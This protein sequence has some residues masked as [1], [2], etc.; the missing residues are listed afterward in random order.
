VPDA[1]GLVVQG[2]QA[3]GGGRRHRKNSIRSGSG[4]D[5]RRGRLR[6]SSSPKHTGNMPEHTMKVL[7]YVPAEAGDRGLPAESGIPTE[8]GTGS[9]RMARAAFV[10]QA[11]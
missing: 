7:I 3:G 10:G 9:R 2:E 11:G 4:W 5:L 8:P 1:I 6:W